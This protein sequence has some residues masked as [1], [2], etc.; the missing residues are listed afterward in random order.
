MGAAA[1][2]SC[3]NFKEHA[4]CILLLAQTA[5]GLKCFTAN[6]FQPGQNLHRCFPS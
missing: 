1:I 4:L 6:D 2:G 3:L 5:A